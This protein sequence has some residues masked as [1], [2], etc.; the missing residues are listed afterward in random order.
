[1]LAPR[2]PVRKLTAPGAKALPG[3]AAANNDT[4]K[5]P[6]R[7][8]WATLLQR[9]FDFNVRKCVRGGG[10]MKLVATIRNHEQ[11]RKRPTLGPPMW[12]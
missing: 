10:V 3:P 4:I 9:V 5:R 1:V 6:T 12:I 8:D 2:S 7:T 11:A